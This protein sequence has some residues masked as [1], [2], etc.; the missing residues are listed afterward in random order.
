MQLQEMLFMRCQMSCKMQRRSWL[1]CAH[2]ISKGR[3]R[4]F[5]SAGPRVR[6]LAALKSAAGLE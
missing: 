4:S 1:I 3:R 2:T 5:V 6:D